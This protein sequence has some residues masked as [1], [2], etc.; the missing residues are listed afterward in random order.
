MTGGRLMFINNIGNVAEG[1]QP[2][3]GNNI[4]YFI[5]YQTYW[6][7]LQVFLLEFFG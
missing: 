7:Y 4:Q 1:D 6:M 2:T 3:M 5:T